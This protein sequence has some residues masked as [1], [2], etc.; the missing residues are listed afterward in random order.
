MER[1]LVEAEKLRKKKAY[2]AAID[3]LVDALEAGLLK[4]AIYYR[5]GNVYYDA[6][7]LDLAEYAYKRAIQFEP[8]H[9]NAH[10]NLAVVYRRMGNI[11]ASVHMRRN[12]YRLELKQGRQ[13]SELAPDQRQWL[14][15]IALRMFL[16]TVAVVIAAWL[17]LYLLAGF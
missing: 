17:A 7:K 3:L 5:L 14:R 8:D 9:A 15:G 6:G 13:R 12:A 4:P 16:L 1:A 10:H 2:K 11:E